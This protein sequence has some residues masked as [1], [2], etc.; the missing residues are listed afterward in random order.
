MICPQIAV[1]LNGHNSTEA[2]NY[3]EKDITFLKQHQNS[4][5]R[6]STD[7]EWAPSKI[8][9]DVKTDDAPC[10]PKVYEEIYY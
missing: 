4:C 7:I 3:F 2:L 8:W 1:S 10:T 6:Y 9:F 5:C